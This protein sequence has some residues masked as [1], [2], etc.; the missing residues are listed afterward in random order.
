MKHEKSGLLLLGLSQL[1]FGMS[2]L[3]YKLLSPDIP[4]TLV[5]AIRFGFG[6]LILSAWLAATRGWVLRYGIPTRR[7]IAGILYLGIVGLGFSSVWYLLAV[8]NIGIVLSSLVANLELIVGVALGSLLLGEQITKVYKK[9]FFVIG[10][11]LVLLTVRNGIRLP[12]GGSYGWGMVLAFSAAVVW[13]SC[14]VVGKKLTATLRPAQIAW[15]RSFIGSVTNIMLLLSSGVSVGPMLL[16]IS[17]ADWLLLLWL[18]VMTSGLGFVL[19]YKALSILSI[20]KASILFLIS[21]IVSVTSGFLTGELPL[22]SQALGIVLI[23]SAMWY[24][25][26]KKG[27]I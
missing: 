3:A 10:V 15:S 14:T 24:L 23:L 6:S 12:A 17:A 7:A 8:R 19:Y 20:K 13:G 18:G 2:P 27:A 4:G 16:S 11:G 9:V 1:L 21:P 25:F 26:S 22:W 5:I